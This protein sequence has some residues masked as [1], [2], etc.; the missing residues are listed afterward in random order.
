[1]PERRTRPA[2]RARR[3]M[4][5]LDRARAALVA[6]VEAEDP[7]PLLLAAEAEVNAAQA[8]VSAAMAA[9]RGYGEVL[10]TAS[11]GELPPI[12]LLARG[13][14]TRPADRFTFR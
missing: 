10:L 1:M 11:L 3:A 5:A 4:R 6:A 2:I 7:M 12:P 8:A 9:H 14:L 13:A